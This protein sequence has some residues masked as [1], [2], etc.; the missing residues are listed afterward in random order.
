M[1]REGKK[2]RKMERGWNEQGA[3]NRI[4]KVKKSTEE[5]MEKEKN[6]KENFKE[7]RKKYQSEGR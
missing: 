6:G 3:P 5:K 1:D 7:C 4:K 2:G